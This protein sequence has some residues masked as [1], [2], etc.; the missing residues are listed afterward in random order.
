M[1]LLITTLYLLTF[2]LQR[3]LAEVEHES[4]V[5]QL[6]VQVP[7][8]ILTQQAAAPALLAQRAVGFLPQGVCAGVEVAIRVI[9]DQPIF[10]EPLH[11]L[12]HGKLQLIAHACQVLNRCRLALGLS[13]LL[14]YGYVGVAWT[15]S[16]CRRHQ[17]LRLTGNALEAERFAQAIQLQSRLEQGLT[18]RL[19]GVLSLGST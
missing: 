1:I 4:Q 10:I 15:R 14:E 16:V 11:I 18:L 7:L 6:I 19:L 13:A 8:R 17:L 3:L 12:P 2:L 5:A 9:A